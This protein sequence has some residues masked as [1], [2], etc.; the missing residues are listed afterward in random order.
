MP[1]ILAL[2]FLV[3]PILEIAFLIQVGEVIGFVP[4]FI[5]LIG[6]SIAGGVLA[7]REGVA[8]FRRFQA[9]LAKGEMPSKE[10]ID[11]V[12]I[13]FGAALL[14]TPGFLTDFLGLA[15]LIP[16]SRAVVRRSSSKGVAWLAA[17]RFPILIPLGL[18]R[19]RSKKVKARTVRTEP[20]PP[21]DDQDRISGL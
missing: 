11:G 8:V 15:L 1:F 4:T 5:L 2:F 6:I 13:L 18:V 20:P 10:I 9:A 12:L 21:S 3:I 7:K 19:S 16:P 14:L 17:K